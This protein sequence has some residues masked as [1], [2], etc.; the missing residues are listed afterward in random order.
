[1]PGPLSGVR[2]LE[3]TA[4]IL[5][6]WGAQLL[7]D[8]GADVIKV[9]SP[10]GDPMRDVG[11]RQNPGMAAVYLNV[12]R[13]KRS[14]VL[15]LKQA[16]ARDALLRLVEGTDVFLHALRPPAIAR[17]GLAY[18]DLAPLNERL[19]YCGT[20]GYSKKGPYGDRGAYDDL[21]QGG[22]GLSALLGRA[23]GTPAYMPTVMADKT[24]S[25]AVAMAISMAL[26]GREKSGRGQEVEVPMF[27]TMVAFTMIEHLYGETF[28]PALG[29][30]G[31][32]R[33]LSPHRAPYETKDGHIG[34]L[35]YNDRQWR[36]FFEV[37]GRTDMAS[38]ERYATM[39]SRLEN[40]DSI[41]SELRTAMATRST[42][43]WLRDL[44]AA[45]IP[46]TA[47]NDLDDL[48]EDEHLKAIDFWRTFEHPT[49][50]TLRMPD[51]FT[52]FSETPGG[53]HRGPPRH[54]EHTAEVLAEGGLSEAEIA[55]LCDSG[56]AIQAP[57][58]EQT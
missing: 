13:N 40:I 55:A 33:T 50:G 14:L 48:F 52:H 6:P 4:V 2:V 28:V 35:P 31:Y 25:M 27:E 8:M 32:P 43:D 17:L 9:E 24:S 34:V 41:Y 30:T 16:P 29:P 10:D 37:V 49:E 46:A 3:L 58:P 23:T 7:G 57:P 15:D 44:V 5:G 21:I 36:S 19:I 47:I 45:N 22:S 56:A 38:D 1:V 26:F 20:H 51:V 54:G 18:E 53:L 12:N 42:A 39:A 11:P